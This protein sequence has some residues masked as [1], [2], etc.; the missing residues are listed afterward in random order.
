M[1]VDSAPDKAF[2][3][4]LRVDASAEDHSRM[5]DLLRDAFNHAYRVRIEYR[6]TGIHNNDLI[7][8]MTLF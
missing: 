6:V 8:V 1:R 2:G 7:R 4:Q 5:L 3:F